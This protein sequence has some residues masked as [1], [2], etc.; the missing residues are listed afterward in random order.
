MPS[1][2][3]KMAKELDLA[4]FPN[5]PSDYYQLILL[6]IFISGVLHHSSTTGFRFF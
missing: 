1:K 4:A 2:G 3:D 5:P 6:F